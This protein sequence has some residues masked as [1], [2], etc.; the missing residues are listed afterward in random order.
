MDKGKAVFTSMD[1]LRLLMKRIS[2]QS[3]GLWS[4]NV[5]VAVQ[6]FLNGF[7]KK[8]NEREQVQSFVLQGKELMCLGSFTKIMSNLSILLKTFVK[9]SIKEVWE[10]QFL[11][12][13]R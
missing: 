12:P 4:L 10:M 6:E 3:W 8:E 9:A 7:W 5:K 1:S 2:L 11:V 13:K